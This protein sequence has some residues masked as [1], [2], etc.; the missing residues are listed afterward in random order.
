MGAE[1]DGRK[2]VRN[3]ALAALGAMAVFAVA[4][5][6]PWWQARCVL[7]VGVIVFTEVLRRQLQ[8]FYW[9]RWI[10]SVILAAWIALAAVPG[11]RLEGVWNGVRSG[12]LDVP[13][14]SAWLHVAFC[15]ALVASLVVAGYMEARRRHGGTDRPDSTPPESPPVLVQTASVDPASPLHRIAASTIAT[16]RFFQGRTKELGKLRRELKGTRHSIICTVAMAGQGKST[17]LGRWYQQDGTGWA[18]RKLFW[19]RPYDAGYPFSQFLT[20][21]LEWLLGDEFD[22]RR[23]PTTKAQVQRLCDLLRREPVLV[24]LDGAERWLAGWVGRPDAEARDVDADGC[25]A[26]DEAFDTLLADAASWTSGS[27]LLLTTRALP[28]IVAGLTHVSIGD[29]TRRGRL[30]PGLK[31]AEGAKLLSDWGLDIPEHDREELAE[32]YAGHPLAIN[33]LARLIVRHYGGDFEA[34]V[35]ENPS[36]PNADLQIKRLL[37]QA[38]RHGPASDGLL[39]LVAVGVKPLPV[40]LLAAVLG[41]DGPRIRE[42]LARFVDWQLLDFD[43]HRADM[44]ALLRAHIRGT[45]T[46]DDA[47]DTAHRITDWLWRQPIPLQP[48]RPEDLDHLLWAIDQLLEVDDPETTLA[49]LCQQVDAQSKLKLHDW[50]RAFGHLARTVEI[51]SAMLPGYIRL[52]ASQGR[53]DLRNDLAMVYNNRGN[54]YLAQGDLSRAIEDYGHALRLRKPLVETEGRDELR[55]DLAV[56]YN[57]RGTAYSDQGDLARAIE[58]FGHALEICQTLVETEGRVELRNDLA[59]FYNN[60]GTTYRAQGDLAG[61]IEDYG[62]ATDIYQTLVET[63]GR[64]ELRNG[65]AM[66]YNN[67]GNTYAAQGDLARAIEDYGHA[68]RL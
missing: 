11:F 52:I 54:V 15:T 63:E 43:G 16:A 56:V 3:A 8:S 44:H 47:R 1:F 33:V 46:P 41:E 23:F 20:D 34:F 18:D 60:R 55:N 68:L 7:A 31:P 19:C 30:L 61:A 2:A 48:K 66:V 29:D 38:V 42:R 64:D 50:L 32:Q 40:E 45:I 53:D 28:S 37:D 62:H 59:N 10:P 21:I 25:R 27:K 13:G 36:G 39:E 9:Y 58:D 17:L 4:L 24:V 6:M 26:A 51:Y 57:N 65:L 22:A 35:Q 14:A 49:V 67:L 5:L 12:T